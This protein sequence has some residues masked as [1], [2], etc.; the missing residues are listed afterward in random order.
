MGERTGTSKRAAERVR[1]CVQGGRCWG[2]A[3]GRGRGQ[4]CSPPPPP[5]FLPRSR[6]FGPEGCRVGSHQGWKPQ[7]LP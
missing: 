5:P 7:R 1:W 6:A 2:G 3:V 4:S